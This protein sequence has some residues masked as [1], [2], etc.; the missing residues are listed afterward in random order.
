MN[1]SDIPFD[2]QT[3]SA[4]VRAHYAEMINNG[5]APRL[6]EMLA[7][8]QPP[9]VKGLDRSFMQGRYNNEQMNE[10]PPDHARNMIALAKRSGIN[11]SGKYYCA[12][13]ADSRGPADPMAWVDGVSDVK[14]VAQAR[15]L[16]VRGAVEHE[17][18]PVPPPKP[19]VLSDSLTSELMKVEKQRNPT[20]KKGELR[21]MVLAKYSRKRK[22]R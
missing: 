7:L 5:V 11:P 8:Q 12:G 19:K 16:T 13:L 9:G 21:E 2:I 6:A 20:M 17:G 1:T 18:T 14:R 4:S 3:A 10:M 22:G 15:N